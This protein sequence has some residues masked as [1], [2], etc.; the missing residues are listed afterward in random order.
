M[1][2]TGDL[3]QLIQ[4]ADDLGGR[5]VQLRGQLAGLRRHRRLRRA[6]VQ[7]QGDQPLLGAIVQVALD[8][9]PGGIGG[10]HDPRPGGG[11]RGLCLGVGDRGP[12]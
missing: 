3:T 1:Q 6:H 12:G 4:H 10:G 5:G 2:P 11:Q 8:P 9:A 7:G